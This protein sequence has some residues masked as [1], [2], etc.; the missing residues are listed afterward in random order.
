MGKWP[1]CER[2]QWEA[3]A[4]SEGVWTEHPGEGQGICCGSIPGKPD[5][6]VHGTCQKKKRKCAGKGRANLRCKHHRHAA[7]SAQAHR[8]RRAA[9]SGCPRTPS[10][11][12][13]FRRSERRKFV[14]FEQ[15]NSFRPESFLSNK[16][17]LTESQVGSEFPEPNKKPLISLQNKRIEHVHRTNLC[18]EQDDCGGYV[19]I[20][21]KSVGVFQRPLSEINN[22][23]VLN[24]RGDTIDEWI[25]DKKSRFKR[26]I[27]SG[28]GCVF[29]RCSRGRI[30]PLQ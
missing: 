23:C 20:P 9:S 10:W 18:F 16:R 4:K 22:Y 15:W 1:L 30:L 25:L 26:D 13:R 29:G 14:L 5:R 8:C 19:C 6:F 11:Q 3:S 27:L 21:P 24:S 12:G 2:L 7:P 17:F 28:S